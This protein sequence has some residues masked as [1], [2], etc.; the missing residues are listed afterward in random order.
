MSNITLEFTLDRDIETAAQ[1][2]RDKVNL[3]RAD[4]P[5]DIEEPVIAKQEADATPIMILSLTGKNTD[6]LTLTDLADRVVKRRIERLP[7]V[8][9]ADIF[10]ARR[11]A[12]RVWLDA[13][14]LAAHNLTIQDIENAIRSRSV[15]IPGGRVESQWREFTVRSLGELKT[16]EEFSELTLSTAGGVP[17]KLR[18]VGR[19][20][21]GPRDDRVIFRADGE[22]GVAV[23]VVRQSRSNLLEV[24][25]AVDEEL[26]SIQAELPAGVTLAKA[27]ETAQY[28]ER[29]IAE[30][31]ETLLIAAGLVILVIFGFLRTF[32]GTLIPTFAI[33][34]SII[35]TFALMYAF[36]YTINNF[37]LLALILA[38][39]IVVDD[40]IIVLENAYRHQE[41]LGEDPQTA[42][43]NGTREIAAPVIAVTLSLIAVFVPLAFLSGTTGRLLSEF[44][45][46]VAGAIF[47][48]GLVA[49]TLTPM[50]CAKILRLPKQRSRFY[51]AV[52]ERAGLAFLALPRLPGVGASPPGARAGRRRRDRGAG[53]CAVQLAPAGVRPGRRPR[54]PDDGGDRTGRRDHGLHQPLSD[55]DRGDPRQDR[56][57]QQLRE[58]RGVARRSDAGD[59]VRDVR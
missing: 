38:I 35:G 23:M 53:G 45:V 13:D 55:P 43:I 36:G 54:L 33:P 19:V 32:R 42:A 26:P 47:L 29:S 46:T 58:H 41:E 51:V 25:E 17:V 31:E 8:A 10:G 59:P 3:A 2:V 16:P 11:Y 52:G 7:G 5:R 1:D 30:A 20:E 24:A 40:A 6:L 48:S 34:V 39:G 14:R 21:L 56:R 27:Y 50:L 37:T 44:G 57:D 15:E 4:L 12:M 28:V 22:P 18:D 49:L 9:S